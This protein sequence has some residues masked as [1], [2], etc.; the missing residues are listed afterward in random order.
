MKQINIIQVLISELTKTERIQDLLSTMIEMIKKGQLTG[1]INT[2][3]EQKYLLFRTDRMSVN[4][5][6]DH[7]IIFLI[8]NIMQVSTDRGY[9]NIMI[10]Y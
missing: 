8:Q 1:V 5:M 4:Q 10:K 7:K 9:H 2:V 6:K 3:N